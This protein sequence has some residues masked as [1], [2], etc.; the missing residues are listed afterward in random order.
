MFCRADVPTCRTCGSI[1]IPDE[2]ALKCVNCGKRRQPMNRMQDQVADFHRKFGHPVGTTPSFSRPELRAKLILEEA[3]E[4]AVGLLGSSATIDLLR[5]E[6]FD[7]GVKAPK[8]PDIVEAADGMCDLL[9]VTFG[10]GVEMGVDLQ[11]VFDEVHASNMAK[12]GGATRPDGK[13]LK[14]ESW[15]APDVLG[16]LVDQGYMP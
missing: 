1:A 2:D 15:V 11:G 14:P 3:I 13:T 5:T 7:L 6:L 4:T 10:S 8:Q 12:V 16:R 9:Y